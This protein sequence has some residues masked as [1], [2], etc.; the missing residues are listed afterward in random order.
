M[1]LKGLLH[2]YNDG[3]EPFG[4]GGLGYHP[5]RIHGSAIVK[6]IYDDGSYD[7]FD[8]GNDDD[9]RL[10]IRDQGQLMKVSHDTFDDVVEE[11]DFLK[12]EV[13]KDT[14]DDTL[15][16]SLNSYFDNP[17][18]FIDLYQ[19][20][21]DKFNESKDKDKVEVDSKNKPLIPLDIV[22]SQASLIQQSIMDEYKEILKKYIKVKY[23][24]KKK[25]LLY[26]VNEEQITEDTPKK[27]YD[28]IFDELKR[29]TKGYSDK[30]VP[31][32]N[33]ID[34][35][36]VEDI[37][38]YGNEELDQNKQ[39][40]IRP[41]TRI[42][43]QIM[44]RMELFKK[45]KTGTTQKVIDVFN[46][47]YGKTTGKYLGK[48][49]DVIKEFDSEP[50]PKKFYY[51]TEEPSSSHQKVFNKTTL[52][53][54]ISSFDIDNAIMRPKIDSFNKSFLGQIDTRY[55][56]LKDTEHEESKATVFE[57]VACKE[58]EQL[59]GSKITNSKDFLHDIL[60]EGIIPK[61]NII[62][63][64][65]KIKVKNKLKD[66]DEVKIG[67]ATQLSKQ[68]GVD[69]TYNDFMKICKEMMTKEQQKDN[70]KNKITKGYTM[71]LMKEQYCHDAM[72]D[73]SHE[74]LIVEF[75]D[76]GNFDL[77]YAIKSNFKMKIDLYKSLKGKNP[78]DPLLNNEDEFNKL[79][80]KTMPYMG[81]PITLNKLN[82][83][84]KSADSIRINKSIDTPEVIKLKFKKQ[85]VLKNIQQSKYRPVFTA[86]NLIADTKY[87][88][89]GENDI[90]HKL[91]NK[92]LKDKFNKQEYRFDITVKGR[93][94]TANYS[95]TDDIYIESMDEVFKYYQPS[96]IFDTHAGTVDKEYPAVLIPAE[97]FDPF[98]K[99][100]NEV[101][102][103]NYLSS[104]ERI[105]RYANK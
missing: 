37:I 79:F 23:K 92:F 72:S 76:Y 33:T 60:T 61:L 20:Q 99:D 21:L 83:Q 55:K 32:Q 78:N 53:E 48:Y 35:M 1:K 58:S 30:S 28:D 97:H 3:H 8:D 36:S 51:K 66:S 64:T 101:R 17:E 105:K 100:G 67:I 71:D 96:H 6:N 44:N 41:L 73:K 65:L 59:Y 26:V 80:Y 12:E 25:K 18:N 40:S 16:E 19:Q 4:R 2:L 38:K 102:E 70:K 45:I 14:S 62:Y 75:K 98:I 88:P 63:D 39:K 82:L 43:I 24:G 57:Y 89:R 86:N 90:L 93:N 85:H 87:M 7:Y 42:L 84:N 50:E 69:G 94:T 29:R 11:Y 15:D 49:N 34:K 27:L 81:L 52:D 9:K 104:F 5:I 22:S 74:P 91:T 46:S 13:K 68:V 31:I 10:L 54:D 103:C 47:T 95:F 56:T 77:E